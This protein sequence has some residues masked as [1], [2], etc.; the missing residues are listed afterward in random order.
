MLSY[1]EEGMG[2]PYTETGL[3]LGRTVL[4]IGRYRLR[5]QK[6][7]GVGPGRAVSGMTAHTQIFP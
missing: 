6:R 5:Y 7:H 3:S 4:E 2:L 1:Q